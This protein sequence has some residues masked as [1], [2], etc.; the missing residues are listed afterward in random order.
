MSFM[1]GDTILWTWSHCPCVKKQPLCLFF[2]RYCCCCDC[3]CD[4]IFFSFHFVLLFVVAVNC[5]LLSFFLSLYLLNVFTNQ[6]LFQ[7]QQQFIFFFFFNSF[8][9]IFHSIFATKKKQNKNCCCCLFV[10]AC[11]FVIWN[12]RT[13]N[14]HINNTTTTTRLES[15]KR[16][17]VFEFQ[18]KKKHTDFLFFYCL[19]LYRADFFV[20][21]FIF[22]LFKCQISAFFF[23]F[24]V[25]S[26]N[27]FDE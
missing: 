14:T 3:Y 2:R 19:F 25:I 21:V 5:F 1:N 10:I 4:C 27:K 7:Q 11:H 22:F 8:D 9:W 23:H 26:L 6:S 24:N 17:K 12:D 18:P 16:K 13:R 20:V 15:G